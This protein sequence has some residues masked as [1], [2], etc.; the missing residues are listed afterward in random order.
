MHPIFLEATQQTSKWEIG[1]NHATILL[2]LILTILGILVAYFKL[3]AQHKA[4]LASRENAIVERAAQKNLLEE[5]AKEFKPNHGSSLV[6]RVN[7]I[8]VSVSNHHKVADQYFIDNAKAHEEIKRIHAESC[9]DINRRVDG[10]YEIILGSNATTP[11]KTAARHL[12][13]EEQSNE[14]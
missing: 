9:I 5:I 10:I 14:S 2:G 3:R 7:D 4:T 11:R 1:L 6:D 13:R 8:G 12:N